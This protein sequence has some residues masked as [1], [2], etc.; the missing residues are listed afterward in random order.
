MCLPVSCPTSRPSFCKYFTYLKFTYLF[1]QF[2]KQYYKNYSSNWLMYFLFHGM[3][4]RRTI[5]RT[6]I[7]FENPTSVTSK[8]TILC[9]LMQCSQVQIHVL[10]PSA[11]P[12]SKPSKK[13]AAS[14]AFWLHD[15]IPTFITIYESD[16]KSLGEMYTWTTRLPIP[17]K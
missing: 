6:G 15:F 10:P 3:W 8:N 7:W 14:R 11:V 9:G 2:M 16:K 5:I 4:L 13:L 17:V 1:A 12:K